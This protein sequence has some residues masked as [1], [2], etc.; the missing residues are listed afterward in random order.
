M[1]FRQRVTPP[2]KCDCYKLLS[3]F[4]IHSIFGFNIEYPR[5]ASSLLCKVCTDKKKKKVTQHF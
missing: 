1:K 3:L 2:V 5:F 4:C